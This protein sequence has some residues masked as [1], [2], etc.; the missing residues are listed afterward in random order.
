MMGKASHT[1]RQQPKGTES[2]PAPGATRRRHVCAAGECSSERVSL[3][4]SDGNVLFKAQPTPRRA[5][6]GKTGVLSDRD[7]PD[8]AWGGTARLTSAGCLWRPRS[9]LAAAR[10]WTGLQGAAVAAVVV[11]RRPRPVSVSGAPGHGQGMTARHRDPAGCGSPQAV[12]R[13][14]GSVD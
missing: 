12:S 8:S 2:I 4:K 11:H 14:L 10:T 3:L 13:V 9:R 1:G 7:P 6:V 5:V